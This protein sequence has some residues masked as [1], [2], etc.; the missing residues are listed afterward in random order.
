[1]QTGQ[2]IARHLQRHRQRGAEEEW[3]SRRGSSQTLGLYREL[4]KQLVRVR[5]EWKSAQELAED[6]LL[7]A[8]D[9]RQ[10]LFLKVVR[11]EEQISIMLS[12]NAQS[13][14]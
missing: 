10:R 11:R 1:M 13:T 7:M 5:M 9:R 12:V 8:G 3:R 6:L 14:Q 4:V 2:R